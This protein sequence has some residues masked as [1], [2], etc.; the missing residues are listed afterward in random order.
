MLYNADFN[1]ANDCTAAYLH[2]M[3][4]SAANVLTTNYTTVTVCS[5]TKTLWTVT[6]ACIINIIPELREAS[7][8][9]RLI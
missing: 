3:G 1:A 8:T 7:T 2:R 6:Q 4:S 5:S 9:M